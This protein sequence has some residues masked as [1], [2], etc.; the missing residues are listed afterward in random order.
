MVVSDLRSRRELLT[1]S[2]QAVSAAG[3][4]L[5]GRSA[6]AAE[7]AGSAPRRV[8]PDRPV[9]LGLV[10]V[11]GRG[12]ALLRAAL[13]YQRIRI[14]ALADPDR[15]HREKALE[16]IQQRTGQKPEVY[17]GEED[18][19]RLIARDDVDAVLLATPC[20]LHARMYLACFDAGKHFYGEKP[21]SIDARDA[22]RLLEAQK[23]NPGVVAQIGFQRRASET[24][25]DGIKRL[26]DGIIGPPISGRG[27]WNNPWGP[28]GGKGSKGTSF[29]FG[30]RELSGDWM[31]E[32]A[33][34]SWDVLC[35]AMGEMPVAATGMGR[36]DIFV[37]VDPGRN[38]TDYYV[39]HIEFSSGLIVNFEHC[40]FC[41]NNDEYRFQGTYERLAGPKGGIDLTEGKI[42]FRDQ[43]AKPIILP[44]PQSSGDMS[45]LAMKAFLDA[46]RDGTQ[47]ISGITNGRQ[48]TLTGLLVRKA[49]DEKRRVTMSEIG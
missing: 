35:W 11:G 6:F 16:L 47:P 22:D 34:H 33:C 30:R 46:V 48:A 23:K 29:W 31:L 4:L 9:R 25:R 18:Y 14:V 32:Q 28:L 5:K 24:Y 13:E 42:F 17:T 44:R 3:L 40:W 39:A 7:T 8:E 38:V 15:E 10:G 27:S 12:G 37:D 1:E 43:E 26:R 20:H 45:I 36:R 2:V 19:L 49:V 21:L 41:P